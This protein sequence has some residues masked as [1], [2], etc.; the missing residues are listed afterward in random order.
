MSTV[1]LAQFIGPIIGVIGLSLLLN[2]EFYQKVEKGFEK[3]KEMAILAGILNLLVGLVIILNHNIW[4]VNAAGL[5]TL[6]GWIALIKGLNLLLAPKLFF[7][8]A[9]GMIRS[10]KMIPIAGAASVI[11]GAYLTYVGYVA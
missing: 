6:T 11:V 5:I 8:V 9:H 4:E 2:Q 7:D 1:A 10:K 3:R